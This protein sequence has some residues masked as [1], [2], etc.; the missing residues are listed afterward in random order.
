MKNKKPN[1]PVQLIPMPSALLAFRLRSSLGCQKQ[2]GI[3]D[4][5]RSAK[6]ICDIY[7]SYY[8]PKSHYLLRF[9]LSS[10]MISSLD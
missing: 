2:V 4:R 7:S 3:P 1:G 5:G 8:S 9:P 6:N 10:K